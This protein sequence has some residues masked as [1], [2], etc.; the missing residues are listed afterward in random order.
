MN[1]YKIT[2]YNENQVSMTDK[3]IIDRAI[4]HIE[5]M[6]FDSYSDAIEYLREFISKIE[7]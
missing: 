3:Y 6:C 7:D 4:G 2:L 5:D 1:K